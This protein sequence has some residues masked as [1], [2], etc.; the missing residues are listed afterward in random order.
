MSLIVTLCT[1][2]YVPLAGL[3]TGAALEEAADGW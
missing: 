3:K 2:V 1:D